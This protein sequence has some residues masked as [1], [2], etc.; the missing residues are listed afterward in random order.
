MLFDDFRLLW[1]M[2]YAKPTNEIEIRIRAE[3]TKKQVRAANKFFLPRPSSNLKYRK[4]MAWSLHSIPPDSR[5]SSGFGLF[6]NPNAQSSCCRPALL[7]D[8]FCVG[9]WSVGPVVFS[10]LPHYHSSS[11]ERSDTAH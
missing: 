6:Y 1:H 3:G 7:T 9:F 2:G 8:Y 4:I 11:K 10:S 5:A